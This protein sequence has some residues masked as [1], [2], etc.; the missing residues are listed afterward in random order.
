MQ[1]REVSG[2]WT[3]IAILV[4]IFAL[5]GNAAILYRIHKIDK[6]EQGQFRWFTLKSLAL[7]VILGL[8]SVVLLSIGFGIVLN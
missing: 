4:L 3:I 8:A 7:G 6:T 1:I 2:Y 5:L